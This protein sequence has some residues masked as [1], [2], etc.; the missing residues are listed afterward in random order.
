MTTIQLTPS[1]DL[2]AKIVAAATGVTFRF[3]PGTYTIKQTIVVPEGATLE[4]LGRMSF[5]KDHRPDGIGP[6]LGIPELVAHPL[7]SGDMIA[8]SSGSRLFRLRI[9]NV[10]GRINPGNVVVVASSERGDSLIAAIEDCELVNPYPPG[11]DPAL[12]PQGRGLLVFTR[13][14]SG[15][16]APHDGSAIR[17]TMTNSLIRSPGHGTG[18]FAANFAANALLVLI[19][20][21]NII[22]G[23]LD[24]VGGVSRPDPVA[25]AS[26]LILSERNLYR[27]DPFEPVPSKLV[28]AEKDL[29][30]PGEKPVPRQKDD[31]VPQ[32]KDVVLTDEG[33]K[34]DLHSVV[35]APIGWFLHGGAQPPP[36][37]LATHPVTENQLVI[38]SKD[39][40]IE[41][42]EMGI[43]ASGGW[44]RYNTAPGLS[45]SGN[46]LDRNLVQMRLE[47]LQ[48]DCL[49]ND[50]TLLGAEADGNFAP[51][52]GNLLQVTRA[53]GTRLLAK[54]NFFA[55]SGTFPAGEHAAPV[56]GSRNRL[57]IF[58][59]SEVI[60]P[61]LGSNAPYRYFD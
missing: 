28:K 55:H 47:D 30:F 6:E 54:P 40:R 8:L 34:A 18:V 38:D 17:V 19:L 37:P 16:N 20:R 4:G 29:P 32:Q 44:R 9:R 1:D 24:A 7:L 49:D 5:D 14:R 2:A 23:G 26:T 53:R 22:G 39:D 52:D 41:D 31:S 50:F 59:L 13:F 48:I 21:N 46:A 51:G 15:T 57:K 10:A 35:R 25:Y 3:A 58:D 45:P 33:I 12:G 43:Y 11:A 42:F 36:K 56:A 61:G 60:P 27:S